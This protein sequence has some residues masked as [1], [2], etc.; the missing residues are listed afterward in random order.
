MWAYAYTIWTTPSSVAKETPTNTRFIQIG[1]Q[2]VV[3]TVN[4]P[5]LSGEGI[6]GSRSSLFAS[7]VGGRCAG[8]MRVWRFDGSC[9]KVTPLA[10][11]TAPY[12]TCLESAGLASADKAAF[13]FL[14]DQGYPSRL[15]RVRS[16]VG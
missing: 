12:E 15:H 3:K 7:G 6:L 1:T 8:P 14:A 10:A 16:S 11:V 2:G 4:S 9:G 13:T 5:T